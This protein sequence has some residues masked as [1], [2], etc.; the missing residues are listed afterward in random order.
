MTATRLITRSAI[1]PTVACDGRS[2]AG[3]LPEDGVLMDAAAA[4]VRS[5]MSSAKA[6]P[7][8]IHNTNSLERFNTEIKKCTEIVGTF[9]NEPASVDDVL[10]TFLGRR[11]SCTDTSFE[12]RH[13]PPCLRAP[14]P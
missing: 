5:Y 4:D 10:L 13:H 7:R 11:K 2:I 6:R 8:Q 12:T 1:Q 9:A 14:D 3:A